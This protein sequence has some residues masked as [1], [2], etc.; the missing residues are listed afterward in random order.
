MPVFRRAIS[1]LLLLAASAVVAITVL[2]RVSVRG[3][4]TSP[5]ISM[6]I[7]PSLAIPSPRAIGSVHYLRRRPTRDIDV[8]VTW[9]PVIRT[10]QPMPLLPI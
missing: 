10:S 6:F 7:P 2:V 5:S 1:I 9:I 4:R 3:N 8:V